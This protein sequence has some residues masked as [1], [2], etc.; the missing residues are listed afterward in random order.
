MATS[1]ALIAVYPQN[2]GFSA[3]GGRVSRSPIRAADRSMI[4]PWPPRFQSP[5]AAAS[6]LDR[7]IG[8]NSAR[9]GTSPLA[10]RWS[11]AMR[12]FTTDADRNVRRAP[13]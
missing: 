2:P 7:S 4:A 6:S 11:S 13:S 5:V 1:S 12:I 9:S 10:R 8:R 3:G